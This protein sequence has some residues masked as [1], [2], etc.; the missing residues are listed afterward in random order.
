MSDCHQRTSLKLVSVTEVI[1]TPF[2]DIACARFNGTFFYP[3]T[4]IFLWILSLN[5]FFMNSPSYY[6]FHKVVYL[7]PSSIVFDTTCKKSICQ[8]IRKLHVKI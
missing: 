2:E 5:D 3:Y 4:V 6:K 1:D 8:G 7:T